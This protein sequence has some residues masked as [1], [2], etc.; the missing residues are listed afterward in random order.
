MGLGNAAFVGE[1]GAAGG[2]MAAAV[3]VAL[4]GDGRAVEGGAC[5]RAG[6]GGDCLKTSLLLL[7]LALASTSSRALP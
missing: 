6:V 3:A 7:W 2:G 1:A 5:G 4:G